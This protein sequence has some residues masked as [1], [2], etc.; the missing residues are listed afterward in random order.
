VIDFHF[1]LVLLMN[2]FPEKA[3]LPRLVSSWR[4]PILFETSWRSILDVPFVLR[5]CTI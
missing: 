4:R 2:D 5:R 1:F 3:Q